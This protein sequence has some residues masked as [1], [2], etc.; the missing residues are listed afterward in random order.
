MPRQGSSRRRGF[1]LLELLVV[2]A[3]LAAL[4]AIGIGVYGDVP[5]DVEPGLAGASLRA[6]VGGI[7]R[8]HADTGYLPKEG[9]FDFSSCAT[10]ADDLAAFTDAANLSWLFSN[11]IA[12]TGCAGAGSAVMPFDPRSR[13]GW[14]GPYIDPQSR[15][16]ISDGVDGIRDPFALSS[17]S[18]T[19]APIRYHTA[20]SGTGIVACSG[21][22]GTCVAVQSNGPDGVDD[23]GV[24]ASDDLLVVLR[25]D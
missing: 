7:E 2:A 21:A 13:R 6:V 19:G 1:T 22:I 16:T 25:E 5:E 20:L 23:A 17:A 8:F 3:I 4:A 15:R 10:D 11:P 14:N 9:P 18:A 12:P 24:D